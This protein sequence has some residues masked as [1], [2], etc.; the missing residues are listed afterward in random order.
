M[1]DT[2]LLKVE[3]IVQNQ[4]GQFPP[5]LYLKEGTGALNLRIKVN[6][7]SP[8]DED[9]VLENGGV[10]VVVGR[11]P[12]GDDIFLKFIFD[13]DGDYAFVDLDSWDIK[14]LSSVA[15]Q[16]RCKIHI[17]DVSDLE[18]VTS[19]NLHTLPIISSQYLY[20]NVQPT[21]WGAKITPSI[22]TTA[23]IYYFNESGTEFLGSCVVENGAY[24]D[25]VPTPTKEATAGYV[26]FFAGWSSKI[27]G[28]PDNS[29]LYDVIEDISVYAVFTALR[30]FTFTYYDEDGTLISTESVLR[31]FDAVNS[32][33]PSKA[34]SGA[35]AYVFSGWAQ[36]E[37]GEVDPNALKNA[38]SDRSLYAVYTTELRRFTVTYYSEDGESVLKYE[39]VRYGQDCIE[40]PIP[41]KAST[42]Y[43]VFTFVGW[44][45]SIGGEVSSENLE[46]VTTN[47]DLYAIFT[48]VPQIYT[49]KY[50]MDD[51]IFISEEEVEAG[52]DATESPI[53]VKE[54]DASTIYT[55]SGWGTV[56]GGEVIPGL[57]NEILS[58][59]N[60]YAVFTSSR[61]IYTV[62][63]KNGD[64]VI[65]SEE[66]VS[67]ENCI[68]VPTATK[69]ETERER[70]SFSGWGISDGG[71]VISGVLENILE[72]KTVYAQY[73]ITPLF[74]VSYLMEDGTFISQES[75]AT[76]E[77][78]INAPTPTKASDVYRTYAFS[79]WALQQEGDVNI[80]ALLNIRADRV[81]WA[82][83]TSTLKTY[84]VSFYDDSTLIDTETVT[85][86][87]SATPPSYTKPSDVYFDYQLTGWSKTNGGSIDD[88]F[89]NEI[90]ENT[91]AY[92]V[93]TT[94]PRYYTVTYRDETSILST[95]NVAA[96]ENCTQAPSPT[97]ADDQYG[98]YEFIGWTD[99]NGGTTP[100]SGVLQNIL[101]NKTVWAVFE[102]KNTSFTVSYYDEDGTTFLSSE[103]V[104]Q[105]ESCVNAPTPTKASTAQYSYTFSGWS[106]TVGGVVDSTIL[107]NITESKSVYAVYTATLRSYTVSYYDYDNTFISSETVSYGNNCAN[108]PTPNTTVLRRSGYRFDGWSTTP[109]GTVDATLTQNISE[110]KTIYASYTNMGS[111]TVTY[112]DYDDTTLGT[113]TVAYS[114]DCS[115][116][117]TPSRPASGGMTYTFLGWS[118]TQGGIVEADILEWITASLTVYA[119]YQ[120]V[121]SNWIRD[122]IQGNCRVVD[123]TDMGI[124]SLKQNA[125]ASRTDIEELYL[126]D[127]TGASAGVFAGTNLNI[128]SL[129]NNINKYVNG[130]GSFY[131]AVLPSDKTEIIGVT[132]YSTDALTGS[133]VKKFYTTTTSKIELANCL[134]LEE[135]GSKGTACDLTGSP[136]VKKIFLPLA[137]YSRTSVVEISPAN[138][139]IIDLGQ[140]T[141]IYN[142]LSTG[143]PRASSKLEIL[144][145]RNTDSVVVPYNTSYGFSTQSPIYLGTGHIYVPQSILSSYQSDSYWSQYSSVL[146][147]LEGTEYELPWYEQ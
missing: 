73:N 63:Y 5:V 14:L 38:Q 131:N 141:G 25:F 133:N 114:D 34:P 76:G 120:G 110:D 47:R 16:Y 132:N 139:E 10:M 140:T 70:Y 39:N 93:F 103:R 88:S 101:S 87:T 107:Q 9:L 3:H 95:E 40:A 43:L 54:G 143:F 81:L 99:I 142:Y 127:L 123:L 94:T 30:K 37:G 144:I 69:S 115:N 82:V 51:G 128:L 124:T 18:D 145:L 64:T 78:C 68:N 15:G 147:A 117:P 7:H 119:I 28:T 21:A 57:L 1:P 41:T 91:S 118:Q 108:I 96:G 98:S 113:E 35:N 146:A 84:N 122:F 125:F 23:T 109:D 17:V 74:I 138:V 83:F 42:E 116:A 90:L 134:S 4:P 104:N 102:L 6:L 92:G 22:Q 12:D 66:V 65:G 137:T 71:C 85:A 29:I 106:A 72:D 135:F 11:Q 50:Y 55:F 121:S 49:V 67:G 126:P 52:E 31:G 8:S 58:N 44:A 77:D 80:N 60:A 36:E 79:G 33:T 53:P 56:A 86:G 62:I 48:S 59:I 2:S 32:P 129:K 75:R 19:E 61:P 13:S 111:F 45:L 130:T 112:K 26:Y 24:P 46:N 100:V 97:K 27:N 89:L 105:G 136:N 20:I